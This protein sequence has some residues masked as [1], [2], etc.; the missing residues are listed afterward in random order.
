LRWNF[1]HSYKQRRP[2]SRADVEEWIEKH[3][4]QFISVQ[5]GYRST[6][7]GQEVWAQEYRFTGQNLVGV[8]IPC[9]VIVYFRKGEVLG[10]EKPES[11]FEAQQRK[12][13]EAELAM[14]QELEKSLVIEITK[15]SRD[16][17]GDLEVLGTVTN[18][19]KYS[20]QFVEIKVAGL[21]KQ[22]NLIATGT[23]FATTEN[24]LR[25]GKKANFKHYLSDPDEEI[26]QV[27]AELGDISSQNIRQETEGMASN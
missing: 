20:I 26:T 21:N 9:H 13:Q 12:Q 11:L 7:Q 10:S 15:M 27:K 2:W 6:Y 18:N 5:E 24:Y 23:T 14:Q 17:V 4:G 1:A 22:E 16:S 3:Q 19:S 25:P 8:S